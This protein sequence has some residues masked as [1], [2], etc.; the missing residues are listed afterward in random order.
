MLFSAA[1]F[2]QQHLAQNTLCAAQALPY[3]LLFC[4]PDCIFPFLLALTFFDM[5]WY[6]HAIAAGLGQP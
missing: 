2:L 1:K 5:F 4:V 3:S 6:D